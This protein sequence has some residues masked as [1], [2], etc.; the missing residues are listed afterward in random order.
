MIYYD[1]ESLPTWILCSSA[2]LGTS[3]L[4]GGTIGYIWVI[5]QNISLADLGTFA[6]ENRRL[7]QNLQ[8]MLVVLGVVV[9]V[10]S[11]SDGV[12]TV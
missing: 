11:F 6:K 4:A 7:A 8:M 10:Y 12:Q 2:G 3:V 9:L 5:R 1:W